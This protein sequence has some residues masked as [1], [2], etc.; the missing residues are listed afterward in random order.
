MGL[1]HHL[2]GMFV[3]IYSYVY[4][5]LGLGAIVNVVFRAVVSSRQPCQPPAGTD[6]IGA[7]AAPALG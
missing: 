4:D 1:L 2:W 6:S 7:A 5:L 3:R